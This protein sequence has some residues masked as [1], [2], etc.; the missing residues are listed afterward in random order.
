RL[1]ITGAVEAVDVDCTY[2]VGNAPET[3]ALEG[4]ASQ[5]PLTEHEAARVPE[6]RWQP[7]VARSA[8]TPGEHN[9][10]EVDGGERVTHVRLRVWPDGGVAR[11]RVIGRAAPDWARLVA[12]GDAVDLAAVEH[13]G[14]IARA[15]D[16]FFVPP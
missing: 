7:L 11:L 3:V 5:T 13:G 4:L 12:R 2:F 14:A 8:V 9:W 10:F 1:G 16:A 15:N 6:E